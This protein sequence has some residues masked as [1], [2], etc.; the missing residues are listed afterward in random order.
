[1]TVDLYGENGGIKM[2][3]KNLI[4]PW[5]GILGCVLQNFRQRFGV[6]QI[7][8]A[9]NL[10]IGQSA[11]AK[12]EKGVV[13]CSVTQ[14]VKFASIFHVEASFILAEA[15]CIKNK[16]ILRG[17]QISYVRVPTKVGTVTKNLLIGTALAG[18]LFSFVSSSD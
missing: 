15:E 4:V 3:G 12:I 1:M 2:Q 5:N 16:C 7:D 6:K 14:L 10:G 17:Y 9:R 11:L 8:V 13:D 18:V